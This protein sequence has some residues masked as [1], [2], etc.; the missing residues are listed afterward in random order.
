MFLFLIKLVHKNNQRIAHASKILRNQPATLHKLV[1]PVRQK[2]HFMS[3]VIT[4]KDPEFLLV[5]GIFLVFITL[6][7]CLCALTFNF[8]IENPIAEYY[9][10][11]LTEGTSI[12]RRN[13]LSQI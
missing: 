1:R 2:T 3:F 6:V 11:T 9:Y 12:T 13:K 10:Y 4:P 5:A 7:T 8:A